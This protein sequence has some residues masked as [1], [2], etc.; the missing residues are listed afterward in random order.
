MLPGT[1]AARRPRLRLAG[2]VV[3][4]L[5]RRV[6]AGTVRLTIDPAAPAVAV[7]DDFI[8]LGYGMSAA[9]HPG[10]HSA[11]HG[12]LARLCRNLSGRSLIRIG[13]N[14]SDHTRYDPHAPAEPRPQS[15]VTIIDRATSARSPRVTGWRVMWG[16]DTAR[17]DLGCVTVVNTDVAR[18]ADVVATVPAGVT[19]A[20]AAWLRARSVDARTGVTFAGSAVAAD[21]AFT[22][23]P[24]GPVPVTAGVARLVVPPGSAVVLRLSP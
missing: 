4:V 23:A 12:R 15:G 13:G 14:V 22:A 24:P 7:A 21:G 2:L 19:T 6:R 10:H 9:V 17:S 5:A 16:R 1:P 20:A 3:S 18:D 11:A 8:G